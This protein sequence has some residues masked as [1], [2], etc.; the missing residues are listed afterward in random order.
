M[1][2]ET[3]HECWEDTLVSP[4]LMLACSDSRHYCEISDKVYRV[5]G[6]RMSKEERAMIHGSDERIPIETLVKTAEFYVRL[7]QKL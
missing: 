1:L 4:Y 3:I 6:M 2:C 5:S 7:I